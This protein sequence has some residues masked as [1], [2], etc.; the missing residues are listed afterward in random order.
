MMSLGLPGLSIASSV[1]CS[2]V[3]ASPWSD[4]AVISLQILQ[5]THRPVELQSTFSLQ[6]PVVPLL[7]RARCTAWSSYWPPL[8]VWTVLL[9][10]QISDHRCS[11]ICGELAQHRP[12]SP[13]V[14][15]SFCPPLP[16]LFPNSECWQQPHQALPTVRSLGL[17]R[18]DRSDQSAARHLQILNSAATISTKQPCDLHTGP[19]TGRASKPKCRGRPYWTLARPPSTYSGWDGR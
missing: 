13:L 5:T 8:P 7:I 11:P 14:P 15:V 9:V 19:P 17:E 16:S 3:A 6:C 1:V 18:I 2:S 4:F 12:L 10:T